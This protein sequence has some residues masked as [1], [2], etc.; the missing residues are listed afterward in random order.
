MPRALVRHAQQLLFQVPVEGLV[1]LLGFVAAFLELLEDSDFLVGHEVQAVAA[2]EPEQVARN[3]VGDL[4]VAVEDLA[5]QVLTHVALF[6]YVLQ[7]H[8]QLVEAL[9]EQR[10]A[11]FRDLF[12]FAHG[13]QDAAQMGQQSQVVIVVWIGHGAPVSISEGAIIGVRVGELGLSG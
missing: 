11:F 13:K 9:E 8:D 7:V 6:R 10:V 3:Q 5:D 12:G 4:W 1:V 2:E